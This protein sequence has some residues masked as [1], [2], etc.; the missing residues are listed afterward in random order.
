MNATIHNLEDHRKQSHTVSTMTT[1][2]PRQWGRRQDMERGGWTFKKVVK[3]GDVLMTLGTAP[4]K[5]MAFVEPDGTVNHY[6]NEG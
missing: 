2:N 1:M 5:Q 4:I 3:S 6:S